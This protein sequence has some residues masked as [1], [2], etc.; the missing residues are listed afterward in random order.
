MKPKQANEIEDVDRPRGKHILTLMTYLPVQDIKQVWREMSKQDRLKFFG[1][2][3]AQEIDL[4]VKQLGTRPTDHLQSSP[5]GSRLHAL[6][7]GVG[8]DD[9]AAAT[10]LHDPSGV[11]LAHRAVSLPPGSPQH[12]TTMGILN[13]R[14]RSNQKS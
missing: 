8:M 7:S 3:H 1:N 12:V 4:L 6:H 13:G 14:Y 9:H 11:R 10:V 2:G 5:F